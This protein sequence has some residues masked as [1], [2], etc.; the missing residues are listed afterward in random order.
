MVARMFYVG[1]CSVCTHGSIG[2]RVAASGRVVG[3]CDEC[4]AVWFD[5]ALLDGP[6][7]PAGPDLS[8]DGVSLLAAPA[9]WA[10]HREASE[11]GWADA[12]KGLTDAPSKRV[13]KAPTK[14]NPTEPLTRKELL[15]IRS[16]CERASPGPWRSMIEGRDQTSGSSFIM[17]GSPGRRGADIELS[18]ATADDQD[19]IAHARQDIPRLLEEV[20]RLQ[21]ALRSHSQA[22]LID[23]LMWKLD[24]PRIGIDFNEMVGQDLVL[25]S[26]DD[27]RTDSSGA[28]IELSPGLRVHLYDDDTDDQG[29]PSFLLA[30]G[31]VERNT[32]DDWSRDVRWCCRIDNWE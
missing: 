14:M 9:H 20:E 11:A 13:S 17:T 27:Q 30:T 21:L 32:A 31:L 7:F 10:V 6:H 8:C 24:R 16:R 19:L 15:E 2:I 5:P 3:L 22:A 4:Y 26:R 1:I 25:L 12:V 28:V 29:N 18:G 23:Q